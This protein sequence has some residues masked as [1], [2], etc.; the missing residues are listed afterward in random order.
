MALTIVQKNELNQNANGGSELSARR[1]EAFVDKDLLSNFQ[2]VLSRVRDL[3]PNKK[4]ILWLH[5][6]PGDPE[7][8][9]LSDPKSRARFDGI[10][11][12]SHW[13][14]QMYAIQLGIPYS[15]LTVIQNAIE[16]FPAHDKPKDGPIR[17]IYHTTPHR[18]L[19]ILVPVFEKLCEVFDNI[20]LDVY[21]SFKIYGWDNRDK[22]FEPLFERCRNHP[23][24]NYHGFVPNDEIRQALG[25]SHIF[26]YSN[27]WMESSCLAAI[28]ALAAGCIMVS[29]A[30]AAL[31]ET[32]ANWAWMYPF[33]EDL[34]SHAERFL[35]NLASAIETYR[36]QAHMIK[37]N[38]DVQ[39]A[40]FNHFYSWE[41]RAKE[42]S[43]YLRTKL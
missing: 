2:I 39:V 6:L 37:Q 21:S 10:V 13:Q 27:T 30:Y 26:A 3:D 22:D 7:S 9:H 43:A 28:E 38:L 16:P 12:V 1:L 19:N 32:T 23:K 36:T 14:A 20:E 15:E 25:R 33:T 40:Y 11:C 34:Q 4:K 42:W 41:R 31:P 29:P 18:G 8:A 35:A 5:D 17:L 24:I